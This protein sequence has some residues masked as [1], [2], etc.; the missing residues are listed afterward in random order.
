M[1]YKL[2]R[3]RITPY[4]F[5]PLPRHVRKEPLLIT[6]KISDSYYKFLDLVTLLFRN[7]VFYSENDQCL[8][9]ITNVRHHLNNLREDKFAIIIK[10]SVLILKPERKPSFYLDF[11]LS[12]NSKRTKIHREEFKHKNF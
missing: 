12:R 3:L 6:V 9:W 11:I 2:L 8:L 4:I 5:F 7:N 10:K 1:D